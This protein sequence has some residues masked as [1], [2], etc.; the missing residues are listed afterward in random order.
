M[1]KKSFTFLFRDSQCK[2]G[3]DFLDIRYLLEEE[4]EEEYE[5]TVKASINW[6]A[7]PAAFSPPDF[8]HPR[9]QWPCLRP[10]SLAQSRWRLCRRGPHRAPAWRR[11]G[12]GPAAAPCS[13][14][15]P[16]FHICPN[17]GSLCLS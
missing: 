4:E 13:S 9:S 17:L 10:V 8:L 7:S 15:I 5:Y 11:P 1:P 2:N 6:T 16:G 3:Q 12:R 14:S